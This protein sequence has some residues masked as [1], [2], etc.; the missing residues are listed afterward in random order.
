ML[1]LL[2]CESPNDVVGA[3]RTV[4][5]RNGV[6]FAAAL[7][8]EPEGV[9]KLRAWEDLW[10]AQ[11]LAG[12]ESSVEIKPGPSFVASDFSTVD[13]WRIR[14]ELN[15]PREAFVRYPTESVGTD[16]VGWAGWSHLER[17]HALAT[18]FDV[19]VKEHGTDRERLVPI[20]A[21]VMEL[22]PWLKQWHN[23]PDPTREG[24]RMG[25]AYA[26]FVS[27]KARELG[28]TLEELRA[29]RPTKTKSPK[30]P[31]EPKRAKKTKFPPAEEPTL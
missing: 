6:A 16:Y 27:E 18:L 30:P 9:G 19:T 4:A 8:L 22:L 29:W 3:L 26:A 15:V 12:D 2:G 5:R 7:Y 10:A 17:A 31:N 28:L 13:E 25:D 11:R 1:S 23:D 21:G 24:E 14:R 20:L